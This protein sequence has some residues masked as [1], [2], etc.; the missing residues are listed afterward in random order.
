MNVLIPIVSVLSIFIAAPLIVFS[1][2]VRVKKNDSEL[3]KLQY[4]KE[5]LE[6]ALKKEELQIRRLEA[7]NKRY[8]RLLSE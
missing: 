1:F 6:L 7:E 4:Q 8:D 5:L 2:I 3:T